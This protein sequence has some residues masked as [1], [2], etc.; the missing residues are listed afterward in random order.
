M[1]L[2]YETIRTKKQLKFWVY[3]SYKILTVGT[4]FLSN[5]GCTHEKEF[6]WLKEKEKTLKKP[7]FHE[8]TKLYYL[9][10]K[11]P[12]ILQPLLV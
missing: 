2:N 9:I 10:E 6:S 3:S 8:K 1:A 7:F 12:D 11:T 4:W 5:L